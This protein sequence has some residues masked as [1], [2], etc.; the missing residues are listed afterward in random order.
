VAIENEPWSLGDV[1]SASPVFALYDDGTVIYLSKTHWNAPEYATVHLDARGLSDLLRRIGDLGGLKGFY[2]VS[3]MVHEP[4]NEIFFWDHGNRKRVVVHGDIR[5]NEQQRAAAPAAFR[6]AWTVLREYSHPAAKPWLP[7][8]LEV[9][10]HAYRATSQAKPVSWPRSWP[11]LGAPDPSSSD[12][13][14]IDLDARHLSRLQA[15]R[16][17]SD[18]NNTFRFGQTTTTLHY[19]YRF[20]GEERW[21]TAR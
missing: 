8:R 17:G 1:V 2:A 10:V 20:P 19:R 5:N 15:L 21:E 9:W 11:C 3:E 13:Y 6:T 12:T 16:G 7:A 4:V 14:S 18:I